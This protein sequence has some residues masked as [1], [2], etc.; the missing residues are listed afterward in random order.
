MIEIVSM[1]EVYSW[2]KVVTNDSGFETVTLYEQR[3]DKSAL[4]D[5]E[6]RLTEALEKRE[7]HA[8]AI[9]GWSERYSICAL[10]W[11]KK[12]SVPAILMSDSTELDE[13]R[14]W[15]KEWIKSLILNYFD[16]AFVAGSSQRRYLEKLGFSENRITEGYDVVDNMHFS[17]SREFHQG[18]VPALGN[19]KYFLAVSRFVPKKNITTL[20]R[21]YSIYARDMDE[22]LVWPLVLV[23]DGELRPTIEK[24]L[25]DLG[26]ED[27]VYLPGFIQ[28]GELPSYYSNAGTFVHASISDQWGLAVNEAMASGLPILVSERCGCATDLVEDGRNGFK[29]DPFDEN[30]LASQ[31]L[32]V[33][34]MNDQSRDA[35]GGASK[36]IIDRWTPE[37]FAD[38]LRQ[39]VDIATVAPGRRLH[40]IDQLLLRL[41]SLR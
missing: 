36:D 17:I 9:P 39:A 20:I 28:Y 33:T 32:H 23:G 10:L 18:L 14:R 30:E 27:L 13:R 2:E 15:Y 24:L 1:D 34:S 37:K 7:L 3:M 22:S 8:V 12:N 35:L 11:C 26:I 5:L 31:M 6:I 25:L 41:V 29:F 40:L 19:K 4:G 38:G 16:A 21:A